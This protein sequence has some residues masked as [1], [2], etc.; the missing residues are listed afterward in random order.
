[1]GK[2]TARLK[3]RGGTIKVKVAN[4]RK[5][6]NF[7][8]QG[9]HVRSNYKFHFEGGNEQSFE[10]NSSFILFSAQIFCIDIYCNLYNIHNVIV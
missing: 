3:Q 7:N 4:I 5:V 10:R 1:M 8:T 6:S 2:A 9:K